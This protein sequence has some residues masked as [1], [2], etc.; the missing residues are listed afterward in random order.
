MT[1][2]VPQNGELPWIDD[3]TLEH[4]GLSSCVCRTV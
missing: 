3:E 4:E 2:P 1:E